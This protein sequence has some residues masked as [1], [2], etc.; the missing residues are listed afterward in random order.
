MYYGIH[1]LL[2]RVVHEYECASFS[3]ACPCFIY[4]FLSQHEIEGLRAQR[5]RGDTTVTTEPQDPVQQKESADTEESRPCVEIVEE[6]ISGISIRPKDNQTSSPSLA[7]GS[8]GDSPDW[9]FSISTQSSKSK[10]KG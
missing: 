10:T 1:V 6:G 4:L 3:P 7:G 5:L 2:S 9:L 8:L